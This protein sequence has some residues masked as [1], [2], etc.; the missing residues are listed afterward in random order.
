MDTIIQLMTQPWL[1]EPSAN[2]AFKMSLL[3]AIKSGQIDAFEKKITS[4]NIISKVYTPGIS[5][6]SVNVADDWDLESVDIPDD[7]IAL[8][9]VEGVIYPWKSFRLE[10]KINKVNGNPKLLGAVILMNTPGGAVHRVDI[11]SDAI[12]N[13]R[14]PIAA[15][16]TGVCA[17]AGMYLISGAKKI[18]SASKLDK[19]GS[20]GVMTT[21]IDDKKFWEDMG[22]TE[23]DYYATLSTQKN[24]EQRALEAG[25]SAPLIA[26]L[27]YVNEQ[28]HANIST[29]RGINYDTES[30]VFRGAIFYAEEAISLRL[31]DGMGTLQEALNWV[32]AEGLKQQANFRY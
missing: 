31:V 14:K 1:I 4:D 3:S 16:I 22:I 18:F 8:I 12:K 15:Y 24:H 19:A 2:S 29:N 26:T 5:A 27:D 9:Y 28:F 10:D 23:T 7:S 21:Y 11:A 30:P 17:S 13:S 20:I 32:L 6:Q 25:D